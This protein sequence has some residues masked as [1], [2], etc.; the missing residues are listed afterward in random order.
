MKY[1]LLPK[2]DFGEEVCISKDGLH[3]GKWSPSKKLHLLFN[4]K[5]IIL[6]Y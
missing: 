2:G 3:L 6:K 1:N 5:I 4:K